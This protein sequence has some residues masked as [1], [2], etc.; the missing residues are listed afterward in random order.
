MT[1]PE[2]WEEATARLCLR[3]QHTMR[4]RKYYVVQVT[5]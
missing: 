3:M 5:K 2:E 4:P 1:L